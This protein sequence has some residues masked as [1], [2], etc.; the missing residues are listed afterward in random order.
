MILENMHL[1]SDITTYATFIFP[2]FVIYAC[3]KVIKLGIKYQ[4]I[5][6]IR[7]GAL[8]FGCSFMFL[9]LQANWVIYSLDGIISYETNTLWNI[10]EAGWQLTM[11]YIFYVFYKRVKNDYCNFRSKSTFR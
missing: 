7:V 1:F 9:V 8:A 4:E 2:L 3:Y 5:D 6:Y 10:Q 11:S